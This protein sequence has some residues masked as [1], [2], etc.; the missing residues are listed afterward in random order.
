VTDSDFTFKS[1]GM[2]VNLALYPEEKFK[3]DITL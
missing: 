2:K 3:K 1:D